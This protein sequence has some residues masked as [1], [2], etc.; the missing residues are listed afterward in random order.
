MTKLAG[1]S[2][3]D[4]RM[5][6]EVAR[7]L[8]ENGF[9]IPGERRPGQILQP[10]G[11]YFRNDSSETIPAWACMEVTG[12]VEAGGQN[13]ITVVKPTTSGVSFLF[14]GQAP[15]TAG[16]YGTAQSGEII[17]GY[18]DTGTVTFGNRWRPTTSQWYLTKGIGHY[19]IYGED[20]IATNVMRVRFDTSIRLYRFNLKAAWSGTPPKASCDIF[21]LDGTDTGIDE[22]VYDYEEIFGDLT[23]GDDGYCVYQD[24]KL[25][26][27][28]APCGA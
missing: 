9:V 15:V 22:D 28:Q 3:S 27:I 11:L 1:F 2:P 16:K 23:T 26:T 14:N 7:Y 25:T 19:V 17:R 5:V 12:T 20:D 10:T 21:E 8:R 13:Y 24:N 6:L 4:A 18:K